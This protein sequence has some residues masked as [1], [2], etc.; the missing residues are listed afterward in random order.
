MKL[1]W[2]QC[3][4]ILHLLQ[5]VLIVGILFPFKKLPARQRHIQRW[6]AGLVRVC[7]ITVVAKDIRPVDRA[8]IICNHVSWLDIFAI[9]AVQPCR[10]VSKA[11]VRDWPVIG[12]LC[13]HTGTFFIERGRARDVCKVFHKLAKN[14]KDGDR[15][16]FFPEGTTAEPGTLLKFHGNLFESAVEA[17]VPV[18]PYAIRYLDKN[19]QLSRAMDFTG[20]TTILESMRMVLLGGPIIAELVQLPLIETAGLDRRDISALSYR[21]I[22]TALGLQE[23]NDD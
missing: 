12:W 18:L 22:A 16:A 4:V 21:A 15:V 19:G 5:G 2:K 10:F 6:S 17:Q 13:Y 8:M 11:D 7:G 23:T 14:I 1:A 9:N 20:D 3:R